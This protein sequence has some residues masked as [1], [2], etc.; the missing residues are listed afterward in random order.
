MEVRRLILTVGSTIPQARVPTRLNEKEKAGR[1]QRSFLSLHPDY[2]RSVT[3]S[4]KRLPPAL[5]HHDG[6]YP[7]VRSQN[8]I[9][10]A[11]SCFCQAF[12]HNYK[13]VTNKIYINIA[14]T[15]T[16]LCWSLSLPL[17]GLQ[18]QR[19]SIFLRSVWNAKTNER[20]SV[21]F[22]NISLEPPV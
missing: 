9:L 10:S 6:L 17:E 12:C 1:E 14:G 13:K 19:P 15:S 7:W 8:Y 21:L 18:L 5:S 11:P 2:G 4:L 22:V 3:T 20:R 16:T